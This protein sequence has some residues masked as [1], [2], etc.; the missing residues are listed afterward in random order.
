MYVWPHG[1]KPVDHLISVGLNGRPLG[2]NLASGLHDEV[3]AVPRGADRGAKLK[4]ASQV[5]RGC[6]WLLG[7]D[8][9]FGSLWFE[10]AITPASELRLDSRPPRVRF[11]PTRSQPRLGRPLWHH[12]VERFWR[13]IRV[14]SGFLER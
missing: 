10:T 2:Q 1:S 3:A 11:F 8:I 12:R 7:A 9:C 5:G 14:A 6:F 4:K 13:A